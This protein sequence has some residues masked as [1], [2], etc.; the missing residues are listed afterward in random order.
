MDTDRG[1]HF[2]RLSKLSLCESQA[3]HRGGG[4]IYANNIYHAVN[5]RV[6]AR[7]SLLYN[8]YAGKNTGQGPLGDD[9]F[10]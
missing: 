7:P 8:S 6:E 9:C 4:S 10:I 5:I 1:G 2:K 3:H